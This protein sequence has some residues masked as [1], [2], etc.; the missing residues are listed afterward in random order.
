MGATRENLSCPLILAGIYQFVGQV[1][2]RPRQ[3]ILKLVHS[4][5]FDLVCCVI[6]L[7][8]AITVGIETENLATH[9]APNSELIA[10]QYAF[11]VWYIFELAL[12]F[13]GECQSFFHGSNWKW[14]L[15]DSVLVCASLVD[16][17]TQAGGVKLGRTFRSIGVFR[18]IRAIRVVRLLRYIEPLRRMAFAVATSVQTLFWSLVMLFFVIYTFAIFLTT[19]VSQ[20]LRMQ[21]R[22]HYCEEENLEKFFGSMGYSI[23]TLFLSISNGRS[24]G[25]YMDPL[26]CVDPILVAMFLVFIMFVFLV[27]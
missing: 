14:N 9:D 27:S 15:M 5:G 4:T 21:D 19:G 24:W 8:N 17:F 3:V 23:K 20:F 12:R 22:A 10:M 11:N 26:F 1:R 2:Y 25:E 13:A 7:M 16:I 18:A 6:I